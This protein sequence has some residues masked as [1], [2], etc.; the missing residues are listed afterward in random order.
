LVCYIITFL[1]I[2]YFERVILMK[3]NQKKLWILCLTGLLLILPAIPALAADNSLTIGIDGLPTIEY[4]G[5]L[6]EPFTVFISYS[7]INDN[8]CMFAPIVFFGGEASVVNAGVKWYASGENNHGFY[9]G[10]SA[11]WYHLDGATLFEDIY[12]EG[13]R[14]WQAYIGYKKVFD[15]GFTLAVGGTY[16]VLEISRSQSYGVGLTLKAGYSW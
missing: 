2:F 3:K 5:N 1:L 14:G 12:I 6:S 16:D 15:S 13:C 4:E 10:V 7:Y 8:R 9:L 11:G